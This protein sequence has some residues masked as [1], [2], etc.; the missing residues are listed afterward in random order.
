MTQL[1]SEPPQTLRLAAHLESLAAALHRAP[2]PLP[3]RP[4]GVDHAVAS[5]HLSTVRAAASAL[6]A[7]A[8][9]LLTDADRLYLVAAAHR[10]AEEQ[11]ATY[12]DRLREPAH[13]RGMW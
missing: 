4:S 13:P 6:A 2:L 10:R 3:D 12:L 7:L 11:S 9:G 1:T 8:D 5:A